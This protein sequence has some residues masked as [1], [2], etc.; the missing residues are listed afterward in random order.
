MAGSV[1]MTATGRP[2]GVILPPFRI[3]LKNSEKTI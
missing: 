2:H 1:R 3:F